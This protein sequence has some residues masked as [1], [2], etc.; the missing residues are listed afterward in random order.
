MDAQIYSHTST[1]HRVTIH[2]HRSTHHISG[3]IAILV[4]ILT[5]ALTAP[6][7]PIATLTA[8]SIA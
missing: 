2:A 6:Q 8:S 1:S 7:C 5:T 4:A 3:T